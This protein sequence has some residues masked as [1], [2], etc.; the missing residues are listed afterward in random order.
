ML[1]PPALVGAAIAVVALS[2]GEVPTEP[3]GIAY[4][5]PVLL[6]SPAVAVGDTLRDSL[7]RA[8]P[9]RIVGIGNAGDTIAGLTPTYVVTTVPGKTITFAP[10]DFVIGDSVRAVQIVGRVGDR[11][12]TPA[13]TLDVVQQPDSIG[14]A[15][16]T[17][18]VF[19][20]PGAGVVTS[21]VPLG[22]TVSSGATGTRAGVKSILV[23]YRI[24]NVYPADASIPDTTLVLVDASNRFADSTGLTAVDTTDDS[25][26]ASRSIRSVPFGFDSVEI[27][28]TA[29][30]LK[31]VP[32]RGSPI[33][34]VV[35]TR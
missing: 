13:V 24:T 35:S 12:Q 11:L 1:S 32:L 5:S 26:N 16:D 17:F 31:G 18:A 19:P 3:N 8:A 14:A 29:N 15:T 9:L 28:A 21:S 6:P 30:D 10:G 4:I 25:G 20:V 23:R 34:F 7:G 27:S 2:C 22:V 33:R